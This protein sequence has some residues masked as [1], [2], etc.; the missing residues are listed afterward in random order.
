MLNRMPKVGDTVRCPA[1]RNDPPFTGRITHVGPNVI[2]KNMLHP[3]FVWC[4]VKRTYGES[5][6]VWASHRLGYKIEE[7]Q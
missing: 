1:D 4:T 5:G 2:P 3:A 7:P 6:G